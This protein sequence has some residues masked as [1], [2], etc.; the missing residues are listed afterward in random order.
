VVPNAAL[1]PVAPVLYPRR[2][3]CCGAAVALEERQEW[4]LGLDGDYAVVVE[5]DVLEDEAQ[6]LAL[7]GRVRLAGPEDRE[8]FEH[9]AGL[10]EVGDRCRR[11]RG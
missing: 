3:P 11:E 9:L 7:G 6:E 8:V 5:P 1:T 4:G 10:V 2:F